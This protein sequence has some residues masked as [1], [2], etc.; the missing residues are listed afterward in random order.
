MK[1]KM[2]R[3]VK[4]CLLHYSPIKFKNMKK[5]DYFEYKHQLMNMSEGELVKECLT[6]RK[7]LDKLSDICDTE[8]VY[9]ALCE[10]QRAEFKMK[11]LRRY[12]YVAGEWM[13]GELKKRKRKYRQY[14]NLEEL[15][16]LLKKSDE[17]D[18]YNPFALLGGK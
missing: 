7:R 14:A 6:L 16:N 4:A 5:E 10:Q 17:E 15:T 8:D 3:Q 13:R 12:C 9:E 2:G 1:A 11:K 18:F